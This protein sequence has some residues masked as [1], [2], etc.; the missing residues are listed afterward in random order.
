MPPPL[1]QVLPTAPKELVCELSK[2]YVY[3]FEKITGQQFQ[4]MSV[5]PRSD[6]G[7]LQG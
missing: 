1:L 6:G 7:P 2:R 3:L 4:V 5:S